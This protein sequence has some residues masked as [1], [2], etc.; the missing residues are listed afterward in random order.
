MNIKNIFVV[1]RLRCSRPILTMEVNRI[2]K[3]CSKR[4]D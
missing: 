1:P 3:E 2:L 4:Y